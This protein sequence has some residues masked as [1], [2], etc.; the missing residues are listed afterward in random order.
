R[1]PIEIVGVVRDAKY[2]SLRAETKPMFY[3][4]I[5][6]LPQT[7]STLEVRTRE[8][9]AALSGPIR[10]ALLGVTKDIMILRVVSLSSQVDQTLAGERL[11]TTLCVFFG[12]LA[13]LLASIGLYGVLSYAVA[14]RTHE[15]GVRMALGATGRN[16]LWLV[17]RQ[18]LTVVL[19][20]VVIGLPLALLSTR[21][22]GSYLYGLSPTDPAAITL[23]TLL[24]ILVALLA[25]Y[26][27]ARR[28]TQVD[29]MFA[30]RHE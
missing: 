4:S 6:Q 3:M 17:L 2:N 21:L 10:D 28:A 15:I 19:A 30:L 9:I 14:Q 27:P 18:S 20:G 5:Q 8:P 25:C 26:L 22:L 24:L 16:V 13:L 1:K 7:L 12:G 29:P 11:I 23:A